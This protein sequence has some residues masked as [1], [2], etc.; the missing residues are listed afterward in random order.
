MAASS[1]SWAF[2]SPLNSLLNCLPL[3]DSI[4]CHLDCFIAFDKALEHDLPENLNQLNLIF[5]VSH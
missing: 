3:G 2:V 5:L 1:L 4:N